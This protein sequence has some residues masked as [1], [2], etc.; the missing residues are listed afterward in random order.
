MANKS[1]IKKELIEAN[2]RYAPL[3][4]AASFI[5]NIK[6]TKKHAIICNAFPFSVLS[7][8]LCTKAKAGVLK[9]I[10]HKIILGLNSLTVNSL[11]LIDA[12]K[13]IMN[14]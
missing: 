10:P 12:D 13:K 2:Y 9:L 11:P 3:A 4:R 8:S 6:H 14:N 7:Y 1:I 5:A